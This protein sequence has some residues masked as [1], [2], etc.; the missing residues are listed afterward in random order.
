[1][2]RPSI[3]NDNTCW[4]EPTY[5]CISSNYAKTDWITNPQVF[6][7][8][9]ISAHSHHHYTINDT[10]PIQSLNGT[11]E[12]KLLS[13]RVFNPENLD[14]D[15]KNY[16][17][18]SYQTIS[19]PSHLQM[20]GLLKPQYVNVQYPW[21]GH[22]DVKAPNVPSLNHVA[23]YKKHFVL[24]NNLKQI[25]NEEGKAT[26]TFHGA[27]TAIYVWI[28]GKF[29]GYSED[30]FTPSEF[31]ITQFLKDSENSIVVACYEFSSASW[32]EDQDYWRLHGIFRSVEL[33]AHPS[34][35]ISNLHVDADYS[36]D[37]NTGKLA[38]RANI[39][40]DNLKDITLHTYITNH[41]YSNDKFT[42]NNNEILWDCTLPAQTITELKQTT[43]TKAL[44]WSAEY[45]ALYDLH[46]DVVSKESNIIE[47]VVQPIGF[48][49]FD[50][51]NGI[52]R[53]NGK[54]IIFKGVN[55][56]EFNCD[57]GRAITYDDMVSDVLFCKQH[58]I[59]AVRTSHYPNQDA[60]YDLCDEYGLY[61]IDETNLETHGTW[62]DGHGNITPECAIPGSR[63]EWRAACVNRVDNMIQRDYNH[64]CVLIWSLG[65][66]SFGGDVFRSMYHHAHALD[67]HRPVHY[68]GQTM[69]KS[70]RDTSDI[71]TR[72]YAH[73]DEIEKYVSNNPDK[74]YISCEYMH[75]MGNSLGNMNE[76][77]ALEK[78]PHYQGGFIWDF[79]DQAI[80]QTLP[81]GSTHLAYGGD[82]DDR[83]TDYEF[84]GNGLLFA[85]RKPSPKAIEAKQQYA[86][87]RLYPNENGV[88]IENHQL[89]MNT[90]NYVF[91][92]KLRVDGKIMWSQT[93]TCNVEPEND[94]EMP[95]EWPLE[96][97][98][99]S[100][101][102]IT[103]EVSCTL[104]K[105]T[106]WAQKG[107]ELSFGQYT[108]LTKN[109]E[110]QAKQ[111]S[112]A[113]LHK[114]GT[115][116]IGR[117]NAGTRNSSIE[118]LFSYSQCGLISYRLDEREFVIKRPLITTFRA[119][120][121]NDR[122]CK[123]GFE[124]AQ[125]SVAGKYAKCVDQTAEKL[126]DNTL[127]IVYKYELA[128]ADHTI[129][130]LTY[131]SK[132][133]GDLHIELNYVPSG[134]DL[135]SIPAFGLEWMLPIEY[136]NLEFYGIGPVETYADRTSA[137]R[138]GI[139]K[140]NAFDDFMPYLVPQETGNHEK[141]RWANVTDD[142]GHG[143]RIQRHNS[144]SNFCVSLLPYSS[145]M[146]EEAQHISDLGDSKHMFLRI[147]AAQMGV[148][149]DD[150]WGS[151]VHPEYHLPANKPYSL[152]V[153]LQLF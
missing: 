35:H 47:H 39:E 42:N 73:A 22:E 20:N 116:T 118:T 107:Y 138:L 65:N 108:I 87:I 43:I 55:R 51:E 77:V 25:L 129:V 23:I 121:D 15:I 27:Q 56:H 82:F 111:I 144:T 49:H 124:R 8:N 62:S 50:I 72:M 101:E 98:Q 57:R 122:G 30:S 19:V 150:S 52:M 74:P 141:V 93:Y 103:F 85:D 119:L 112:N 151:P 114:D 148:G 34:T 105:S 142:S 69:D 70:W 12:V 90:E 71:E 16:E 44:P 11:W 13:S 91:L 84:C 83:P 120:T 95:I 75:A 145:T 58:N 110:S 152:N 37:T 7:V 10:I 78:Y 63:D 18:S 135:P 3:Y 1:M 132:T 126:D 97:Y 99:S 45:P 123:H 102:E 6:A 80:K 100:G 4:D 5:T 146:I 117:W 136:R 139:W 60:W 113:R 36:N 81:D 64:P 54:R 38:F 109:S 149:G 147:L 127:Q 131:V 137:G 46:I 140:T 89:F 88:R 33:C 41:K 128:N 153:D 40:G 59:N 68:E 125:W 61:I 96:Q 67:A 24:Q 26:I 130:N 17:D 21:D 14:E 143:M 2:A 48:R 28:N 94:F 133:S 86:N 76:Y 53:L 106:R 134:K 115:V 32:L 66:E 31:D 79:I 92:A 104:A 29:V 9:T